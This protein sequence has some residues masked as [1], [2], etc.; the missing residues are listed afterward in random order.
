MAGLPFGCRDGARVHLIALSARVRS[1]SA[2][3]PAAAP[4]RPTMFR[5]AETPAPATGSAPPRTPPDRPRPGARQPSGPR[6][7]DG[8]GGTT[9]RGPFRCAEPEPR[10]QRRPRLDQ[11]LAGSEEGGR[12]PTRD[13][14]RG[15]RH[16]ILVGE[17]LGPRAYL[18]APFRVALLERAAVCRLV[19]P[20]DGA[21]D[22]VG[23]AEGEPLRHRSQRRQRARASMASD[24]GRADVDSRA[25]ITGARDG[26]AACVTG[27]I[28]CDW[29]YCSISSDLAPP[30]AIFATFRRTFSLR[31]SSSTGSTIRPV[32]APART[33][34]SGAR[35]PSRQ[36]RQRR[37]ERPPDSWRAA[38]ASRP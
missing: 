9:E 1:A 17:L 28:P 13:G 15:T 38:V 5:A 16:G 3:R 14:E 18:V 31:S 33:W 11:C 30:A 22:F 35:H 26:G 34:R 29:M 36:E 7:R 20:F 27:S 19:R 6:R 23:C 25:A 10:E 12:D 8:T 32:M 37:Q 4:R 24:A 2:C 21:E